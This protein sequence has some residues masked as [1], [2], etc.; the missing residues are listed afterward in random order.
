MNKCE[1]KT[2]LV[3]QNLV[4]KLQKKSVRG[5]VNT[6]GS[7][8]AVTLKQNINT[9]MFGLVKNKHA[10]QKHFMLNLKPAP[11]LYRFN[12]KVVL[13]KS[14]QISGREIV[15]VNFPL[16]IWCIW[17]LVL[18]PDY[19][20]VPFMLNI[21]TRCTV[22]GH[23]LAQDVFKGKWKSTENTVGL[24]NNWRWHWRTWRWLVAKFRTSGSVIHDVNNK[25]TAT[26]HLVANFSEE[27]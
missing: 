5:S 22:M 8:Y 3:A 12:I 11:R 6:L 26:V 23:F 20:L 17:G 18:L 13:S 24:S 14:I 25:Q 19:L 21:W 1:G 27:R 2:R 15:L 10:Y 9:A 4:W 7:M 16:L